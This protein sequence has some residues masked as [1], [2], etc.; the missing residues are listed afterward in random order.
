LRVWNRPALRPSSSEIPIRE[1]VEV[2]AQ[3]QLDDGRIV[4]SLGQQNRLDTGHAGKMLT[5]DQLSE[6]QGRTADALD[7]AV[8]KGAPLG[9]LEKLAAA[10]GLLRALREVP[11]HALFDEVVTRAERALREWQKWNEGHS[12]VPIS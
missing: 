9:L 4:F 8:A 7:L 10:A 11:K 2:A 12:R 6:L 1:Q 5:N 3:L